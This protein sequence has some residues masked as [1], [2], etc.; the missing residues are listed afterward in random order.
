V[1]APPK[2]LSNLSVFTD[3]LRLG[4]L[5]RS[6]QRAK[7]IDQEYRAAQ[8]Q[9]AFLSDNVG[10]PHCKD[11]VLK[12]YLDISPFEVPDVKR[13][14]LKALLKQCPG[15]KMADNLAFD[16]A[17]LEDNL[18]RRLQDLDEVRTKYR[19]T[20]GAAQA[21]Y[22]LAELKTNI[23]SNRIENVK[24]AV[25]HYRELLRDYPKSY[26]APSAEQKIR[27]LESTLANA[28]S[29]RGTGGGAKP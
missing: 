27:F 17:M 28:L 3:L 20:D 1:A 10:C 26:L 23:E 9:W 8:R 19:G 14:K 5:L 25:E 12:A 15:C 16:L 18:S 7:C 22:A 4:D 11:A 29:P 21:L 24:Q 6:R 2:D 13:D